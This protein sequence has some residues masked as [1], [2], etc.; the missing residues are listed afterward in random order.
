MKRNTAVRADWME[1][2]ED[3]RLFSAGH[4]APAIGV[5]P[6]AP[7]SVDIPM[8]ATPNVIGTYTGTNTDSNEK[9][10]G[11]L[12]A[13]ILTQTAKGKLTG[14][15]E[16]T[17]PGNPTKITQ[18]TG[19]INGDSLVMNTP[20]T[21]VMATISHKGNVLTGYYTFKTTGDS[22]IGQFVVT[23]SA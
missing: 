20:T 23:R 2:L 12:T 14:Y 21:I 10:P 6:P 1:V 18:F 17:F 3:R 19:S 22:S 4:L 7:P 5:S 11:T 16:S 15:V 13:V 9:L 8:V